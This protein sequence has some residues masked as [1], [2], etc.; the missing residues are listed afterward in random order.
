MRDLI[1][2]NAT[3]SLNHSCRWRI[4]L[5]AGHQRGRVTELA[6]DLQTLSEECRR[7]PTSS[8][9]GS[10]AVANMA[11]GQRQELVE[12]V[13]NRESPHDLCVNDGKSGRRW[14]PTWGKVSTMF[15]IVKEDHLLWP[16]HLWRSR[17]RPIKARA[18]EL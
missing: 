10:H 15:P 17:H 9:S 6:H 8:K 5:L 3:A 12:L 16:S 14:Y 11:T 1:A 4:R 7:Y 2:Q 18:D 13:T